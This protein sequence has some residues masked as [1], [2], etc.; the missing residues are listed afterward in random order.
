MKKTLL[1]NFFYL[2]VIALLCACGEFGSSGSSS[3]FKAQPSSG[4]PYSAYPNDKAQ[5]DSVAAYL[6]KGIQLMVHPYGK[7]TIS[8]DADTNS[9]APELQLYRLTF[10]TDSTYT[11]RQVRNLSAKDSAGRWYYSFDCKESDRAYWAA[12]LSD[13]DSYYQGKVSNFRFTGKGAYTDHVSLNLT[14]VGKYEGTSDS[15]AVD[16]LA[17]LILA[18]FRASVPSDSVTF[19]T[20]YVRYASAHPSLGSKYPSMFPWIAGRSSSD[21]LLTELGGWPEKSGPDVYDA[22]DLVLVYYINTDNVLGLSSVFGGSLGGG[23][24][25]TVVIG[26]HYLYHGSVYSQKAA[27]IVFT[28]VHESGHFFGLRHTTST[29]ADL[30]ST[31]DE[32][33]STD[34]IGDTPFCSAIVF[35]KKSASAAEEATDAVYFRTMTMAA[36]VDVNSCP[37]ADN[38]MFPSVTDATSPIFSNGQ[39]S[40]MKSTLELYPH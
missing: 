8:F 15:V 23:D 36:A 30:L 27:D 20:I 7:Y 9:D 14:V 17:N 19:D 11:A 24:G 38:I 16:S 25:S 26:T 5:N 22:L 2:P 12:T 10:P 37:D 31:G 21:R 3:D 6:A 35:A 4:L 18:R 34:G 32:S 40:L 13:G 33:D 29:S 1:Q 39:V 28:A